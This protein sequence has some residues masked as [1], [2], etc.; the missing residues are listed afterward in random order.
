MCGL[1]VKKNR[2]VP[3]VNFYHLMM[4][5]SE[6]SPD[7]TRRIISIVDSKSSSEKAAINH[8]QA[9]DFFI[10]NALNEIAPATKVNKKSYD[11]AN[12]LFY[13]YAMNK[14]HYVK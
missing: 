2:M 7:L 11:M 9:L 1:Y 14:H 6:I 10:L 12:E 4:E 13:R 3:P 8:D 5:L